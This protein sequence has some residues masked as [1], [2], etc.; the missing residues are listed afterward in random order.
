M[1]RIDNDLIHTSCAQLALGIVRHMT[2][3]YSRSSITTIVYLLFHDI[4][5]IQKDSQALIHSFIILYFIV[6]K[7]IFV[8]ICY[9]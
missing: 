8:I 1:V 2:C 4:H 5:N 7:T 6:L 3:Y 9:N